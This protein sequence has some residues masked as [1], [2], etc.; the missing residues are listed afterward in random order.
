[1]KLQT[2]KSDQFKHKFKTNIHNGKQIS[3]QFKHK[4]KSQFIY[5]H[6]SLI[7]LSCKSVQ[8]HVIYCYLP[9]S[10][11]L[12]ARTDNTVYLKLNRLM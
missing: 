10:S 2:N 6:V 9:L 3:D 1:M 5:V 7:K 8:F 11:H 12:Y 4:L